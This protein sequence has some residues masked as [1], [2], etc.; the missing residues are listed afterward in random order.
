MCLAHHRRRAADLVVL[1]SQCARVTATTTHPRHGTARSRTTAEALLTRVVMAVTG[2][3]SHRCTEQSTR[4]VSC[5][6]RRAWWLLL[7]WWIML[8]LSTSIE[9]CAWC[10]TTCAVCV[11]RVT[12]LRLTRIIGAMA[13]HPSDRVGDVSQAPEDCQRGRGVNKL[14]APRSETAAPSHP[15]TQSIQIFKPKC[16]RW[17]IA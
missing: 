11:A 8:C 2:A 7:H 14:S 1:I 15:R 13:H 4:C 12:G 6:R 3:D 16:D 10:G 17:A 5:A 9:R